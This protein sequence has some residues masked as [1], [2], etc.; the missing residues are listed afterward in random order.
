MAPHIPNLDNLRGR[1]PVIGWIGGWVCQ[2]VDIDT[3]ETITALVSPW[4][5]AYFLFPVRSLVIRRT[6]LSRHLYISLLLYCL[7][8]I[9]TLYLFYL[10]I[11]IGILWQEF[12]VDFGGR[13]SKIRQRRQ[14]WLGILLYRRTYSCTI[15]VHI[16]LPRNQAKLRTKAE[17]IATQWCCLLILPGLMCIY[18]ESLLLLKFYLRV[19]FEVLEAVTVKIS[20]FGNMTPYG[21]VDSF[22]WNLGTYLKL[23]G[24]TYRKTVGSCLCWECG[25]TR[26]LQIER[27]VTV[28]D[29]ALHGLCS[30]SP[31][32]R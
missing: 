17:F 22:P 20:V 26:S 6:A 19:K 5:E 11:R 4:I 9:L 27:R 8:E 12:R 1:M 24:V 18:R 16:S 31:G 7:R 21:F 13:I 3:L 30:I 23:H 10:E 25:K 28:S 32:C 2:R 15:L 29:Y 14:C